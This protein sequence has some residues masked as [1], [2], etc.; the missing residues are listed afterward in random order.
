[1]VRRYHNGLYV[2]GL[3]MYARPNQDTQPKQIK[4][5]GPFAFV[6]QLVR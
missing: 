5:F 3:L 4:M 2:R 1:M 6:S